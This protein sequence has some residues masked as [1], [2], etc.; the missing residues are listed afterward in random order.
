[1][2]PKTELTTGPQVPRYHHITWQTAAGVMASA[3]GSCAQEQ[4]GSLGKGSSCLNVG[5]QAW[6]PHSSSY[7][8]AI[9]TDTV[10]F[11]Y[12]MVNSSQAV[13]F[14]IWQVPQLQLQWTD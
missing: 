1:M 3:T 10:G 7:L 13:G 14:V 9:G 12:F 8:G 5:S 4:V 6:V 2:L 11:S